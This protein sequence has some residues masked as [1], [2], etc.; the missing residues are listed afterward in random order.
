MRALTAAV[1]CVTLAWAP[2]VARADIIS[3]PG[4]PARPEKIVGIAVAD[5]G[6]GLLVGGIIMLAFGGAADPQNDVELRRDLFLAGGICTA[7]GGSMTLV[8]FLYWM[9]AR[10]RT[11]E[12]IKNGRPSTPAGK[13]SFAPGPGGLRLTF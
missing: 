12:W 8:G 10:Q 2:M 13:V 5:T 4:D 3:E 7:V 1:L 9:L 6:I 11:T